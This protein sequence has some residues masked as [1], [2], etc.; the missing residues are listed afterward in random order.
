MCSAIVICFQCVRSNGT[1]NVLIFR[2][3]AG[4]F[5]CYFGKSFGAF[6]I[7]KISVET[8]KLRN[9]LKCAIMAFSVN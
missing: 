9:L 7:W 1:V 4:I 3:L 2:I 8:P 6:Q 5:F